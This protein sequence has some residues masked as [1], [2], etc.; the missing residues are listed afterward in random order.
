MRGWHWLAST[1]V[2]LSVLASGCVT[3]PVVELHSAHLA[4]ANA[5]G[6]G[7]DIFVKVNNDNVFDVKIRNVR[8]KVVMGERFALPPLQFN[9]DQW[10]PAKRHTLVR[11]PMVV[12]WTMVPALLAHTA[13]SETISY[14]VV[15][16]A[17]V[18]AVRMLGIQRNDYPID[19]EGEL[20]RAQ[21]A[22]AAT[23]GPRM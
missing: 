13:G 7:L 8:A 1:A 16:A 20:S 10:L 2:V 11:V 4:T 21:L 6:V 3:T 9:P 18:T 12:P 23:R 15:G 14:T 19:D 17:D 5:Q 22:A